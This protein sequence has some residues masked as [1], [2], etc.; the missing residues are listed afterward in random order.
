MNTYDYIIVG[1]GSAGCVLANRLSAERGVSVLLL[2]AGG[3]DRALVLKIPVYA[4]KLWF[5]HRYGWGYDGEPEPHLEGRFIPVPRGKLLGGSSS[6]NG[7]LYS[8][9]H[10]RD[11][12]QWR[13]LGN[14]GWSY[15]DILPYY[16]RLESDWR[17]EGTYHGGSGPLPVSRHDTSHKLYELMRDAAVAAGHPETEDFHGARPEGFGVPDFTTKGGRRGSTAVAFLRPAM[18]RPN[19]TVETG[20]HAV[21]V[22]L[23][24]GRAV[25]VEYVRAGRS[26]VARARRE[27][28][29]SGGAINSPHL[30]MLSGVGPADELRAHGITPLVDLPG[31]GRNL[32]DHASTGIDVLLNEPITFVNQLRV[33]RVARSLAQWALTGSGALAGLPVSGMLFVRSREGLE[34]PDLQ[35][36]ISPVRLF[37]NLWFPGWRKAD[38]HFLSLRAVLLHPDSRGWIKLRSADP[39][40]KPRITFNL[41]AEKSDYPPLR[42]AIRLS[43]E[44]VRAGPLA[45]LVEREAMPGAEVQTDEQLDAFI[46]KDVRTAFHPVGTCSMGPVVDEQLRVRGVEGLRVVDASVMPT[47]IGGNT[48]APT[49][50][51]AEK[52]SDMILGRAPLA[53]A[54]V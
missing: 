8:R 54:E 25:G 14:A 32:Q 11:Y 47:I 51:I 34:R 16:R 49:I 18:D 36:L 22:M 39:M 23:E 15:S 53:P 10:P 19:L 24:K 30:L 37:A 33:D 42:A 13:Q 44:L 50:M 26:A 31:V 4:P 7:M 6:I 27:V 9:G 12:D 48:N 38:G 17:G 45:K 28:I 2:E 43:R 35:I 46:R 5:G 52:A 20:A 21:R 29:L 3:T 41:L 40:A 1:A